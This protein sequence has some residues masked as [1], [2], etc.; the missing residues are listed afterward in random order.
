M[1]YGLRCN[2][3][4]TFTLCT[5]LV[6]GGLARILS[7]LPNVTTC[8]LHLDFEMYNEFDHPNMPTCLP[9]L[10][11]LVIKICSQLVELQ[12]CEKAPRRM[13]ISSMLLARLN[14]AFCN[15]YST[16]SSVLANARTA[17]RALTVLLYASYTMGTHTVAGAAVLSWQACCNSVYARAHPG[18]TISP[19]ALYTMPY[20]I[21]F[22]DLDFA[23][24]RCVEMILSESG[25]H[26]EYFPCTKVQELHNSYR[27]FSQV[28]GLRI[29]SQLF[30]LHGRWCGQ[31]LQRGHV[32]WHQTLSTRSSKARLQ[33][34]KIGHCIGCMTIGL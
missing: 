34:V 25:Y 16:S 24:T 32:P 22:V 2:S 28:T 18:I 11:S 10:C 8:N 29:T 5:L 21:A 13:T 9:A 26:V 27:R 33:H 31:S 6:L 12:P 19:T 7:A 30:A 23:F 4:T 14:R 1:P 3:I 20:S 17:R 15:N